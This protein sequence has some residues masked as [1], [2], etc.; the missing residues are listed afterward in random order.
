LLR[1]EIGMRAGSA[2]SSM[3]ARSVLMSPRARSSER[4]S[5]GLGTQRDDPPP[6]SQEQSP[7]PR[8][9]PATVGGYRYFAKIA[10]HSAPPI[11]NIAFLVRQDS[12][13]KRAIK[14]PVRAPLAMSPSKS[15]SSIAFMDAG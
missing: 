14:T 8:R 9:T 12:R 6:R 13:P 7:W 1:T 2:K 5:R 10:A 15:E 11:A 4:L 3:R